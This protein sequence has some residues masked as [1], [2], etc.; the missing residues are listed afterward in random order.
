MGP[1]MNRRPLIVA[2]LMILWGAAGTCWSAEGDAPEKKPAV[3]I[4]RL[5]ADAELIV[6]G[7]KM[8]QQGAVR[9]FDTPA[10]TPGKKFYYEVKAI[11]K[12]GDKEVTRE[13]RIIV[14]AG[15]RAEVSL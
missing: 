1:S 8:K 7:V 2:V 5:P 15:E 13:E 3:V 11:W 14:Q 9:E 10:L 6:A 4:V 12:E